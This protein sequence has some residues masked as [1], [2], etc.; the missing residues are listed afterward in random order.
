MG[1]MLS[2]LCVRREK[3]FL[4][5]NMNIYLWREIQMKLTKEAIALNGLKR[6]V[7]FDY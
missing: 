4:F 7:G 2:I 5:C 1:Y 3:S 6:V